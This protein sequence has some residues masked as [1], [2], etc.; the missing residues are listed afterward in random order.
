MVVLDVINSPLSPQADFFPLAP[1]WFLEGALRSAPCKSFISQ[2]GKLIP[3]E[4][5]G[6]PGVRPNWDDQ[7]GYPQKGIKEDFR[8]LKLQPTPTERRKVSR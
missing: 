6:Q 3:R 7:H 5:E 2:K 1:G 8:V 4:E